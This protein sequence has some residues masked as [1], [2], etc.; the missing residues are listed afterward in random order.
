M[1]LLVLNDLHAANEARND[2]VASHKVWQ[3]LQETM[4][5][6]AA[7]NPDTIL[8]LGDLIQETSAT[9]DVLLFRKVLSFFAE[10]KHKTIF[11]LGNH[12]ARGLGEEMTQ[13]LLREQGFSDAL[14]GRQSFPNNDI[15]WLST[16]QEGRKENRHDFLPQVQ[17]DW[18]QTEL[19]KL[20]KPTILFAHHGLRPQRLDGNFYFEHGKVNRM[21][22]EN[23]SKVAPL[24]QSTT[25]LSLIVNGHAHWLSL[26]GLEQPVAL[27]LPAF[28]ENTYREGKDIIP[29]HYTVIET[30]KKMIA[31]RVY[32]G[33]FVMASFEVPLRRS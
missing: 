5:L 3:A 22:V 13:I 25:Q 1:K 31:I 6:I 15:I 27:T 9:E 16:S 8:L 19:P 32:S 4:P 28:V 7:Q 12:E 26:V 18:L 17:I 24:L 10:Y 29:A 30:D 14:F 20:Q 33:E 2:R 23:W 11:A 21:T